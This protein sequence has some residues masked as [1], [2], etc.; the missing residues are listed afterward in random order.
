MCRGLIPEG[1]LE[2]LGE[3]HCHRSWEARERKLLNRLKVDGSQ[4]YKAFVSQGN[5][6]VLICRVYVMVRNH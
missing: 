5:Y 3:G 6:F 4:N 1:A 2:I